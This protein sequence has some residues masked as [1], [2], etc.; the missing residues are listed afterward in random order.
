MDSS[1]REFEHIISKEVEESMRT[2]PG[3]P[4]EC[5]HGFPIPPDDCCAKVKGL[6]ES[7]V[8]PLTKFKLG[9]T[10]R[11]VY[12]LKREHPQLHKLMSLRVVPGVLI[13]VH[14]I[15]PLFVI[16]VADTQLALEKDIASEIYVKRSP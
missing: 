14:Q 5:P 2:L 3:H 13:Q 16:Q 12:V 6:L 15:F 7:I 4:K 11:I 9:E 10:G 1:A 8:V